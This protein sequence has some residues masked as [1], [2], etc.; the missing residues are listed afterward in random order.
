[1]SVYVP[2]YV[3]SVCGTVMRGGG[4]ECLTFMIIEMVW[5]WSGHRLKSGC[6]FNHNCTE[7]HCNSNH[8]YNGKLDDIMFFH[9]LRF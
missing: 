4:Q 6:C 2:Q 5:Y 8:F 9:L 7:A 1:M 3:F